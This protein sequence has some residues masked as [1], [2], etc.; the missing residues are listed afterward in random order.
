MVTGERF[1][2]ANSPP[3]R[4]VWGGVLLVVSCVDLLSSYKSQRYLTKIFLSIERNECSGDRIHLLSIEL[5]SKQISMSLMYLFFSFV[6]LSIVYLSISAFFSMKEVQICSFL[7]SPKPRM[8]WIVS[9][10]EMENERGARSECFSD[11]EVLAKRRKCCPLS[12]TA[13][14]KRNPL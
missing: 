1:Q 11:P 7:G 9:A 13:L 3:R 4:F 12:F 6:H 8:D 14:R 2:R 5:E 10:N